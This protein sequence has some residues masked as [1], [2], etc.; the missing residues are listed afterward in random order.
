MEGKI[1]MKTLKN[2]IA[3]ITIS[4]FFIL[5][6]TASIT[7][8]P[9]ASAHTPPLQVPTWAYISVQPN[10][11][12]IGQA[13]YV[14]FWLDK[15]PPTAEAQYGD[16]WQNFTVQVTNSAGAVT[17]LGHLPP[18]TQEEHTLHTRPQQ[19]VTILSSSSFQDKH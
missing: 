10:P 3:A 14:N 8:I 13:A 11:I 4:V 6:M 17:T 9:N 5:S 12:G 1:K 18:M 15:V 7:L 2:K 19:Q 16:R